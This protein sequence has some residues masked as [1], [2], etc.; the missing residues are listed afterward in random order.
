LSFKNKAE[1]KCL[2][3]YHAKPGI[4]A[5]VGK[6]SRSNQRKTAQMS[7]F[8]WS[9]FLPFPAN[10]AGRVRRSNQSAQKISGSHLEKAQSQ[11]SGI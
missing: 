6:Q 3:V 1:T 8:L 7:G 5:F 4:Y 9:V 10:C 2:P 11:F